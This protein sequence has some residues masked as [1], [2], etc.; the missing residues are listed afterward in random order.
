VYRP[1]HAELFHANDAMYSPFPQSLLQ[2]CEDLLVLHCPS[3]FTSGEAI[4]HCHP[5]HYRLE[6]LSGTATV[7]FDFMD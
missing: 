4:D 6:Q 3:C 5:A 2:A 7:I 1:A